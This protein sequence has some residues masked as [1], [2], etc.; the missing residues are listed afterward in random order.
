M[1]IA[2]GLL[3]SSVVHAQPGAGQTG[4]AEQ[5]GGGASAAEATGER[6]TLVQCLQIALKNR[7]A[8][9]A[10]R[11][12]VAAARAGVRAQEGRQIPSLTGTWSWNKSETVPRVTRLTGGVI[13][14]TSGTVISR[15]ASVGVDL[16]LYQ[17]GL[18]ES[19]NAARED[20]KASV[21]ELADTE[22]TLLQQ[23]AEL[24]YTCLAD[25]RLVEVR[26]EG[27]RTALRHLE[28]VDARIEAGTAAKSDRLPVEVELAQA[29][30]LAVQ[31]ESALRKDLANLR[32]ALG[33]KTE[34]LPRLAEALAVPTFSADLQELA[35]LALENRADLRAQKHSLASL[36]WTLRQA[37]LNARFS[38]AVNAHGEYG[39]YTEGAEGKSWWFGINATL[40]FFRQET[41]AE[42]ER[43][44]AELQRAQHS[45][46][47]AELQVLQEVEQAYL[48]LTEARAR[49]EEASKSL[50]AARQNLQI[51]EERYQ[52]GVANIIEVTDAEQS[53]REAEAQYVQAVYDY[54]IAR[55]RVLSA[56]GTNLLESLGGGQ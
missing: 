4:A 20:E 9:A 5:G 22:R 40:P 17:T 27:V 32:A 46:A 35:T 47:E 19:I 30:L 43:A 51:A 8:L 26:A 37:E 44:K 16:T 12:R 7:P 34:D 18:R 41:R 2:A 33:L 15:E 42:V 54:N 11:A 13:R 52:A 23:V 3:A 31:A 38:A 21:C 50:E 10:A 48:A 39:R 55:V 29:R 24:Y 28:M 53:V 45:L 56:A 49:I 14:T 1:L 25:R 6:L 36:K